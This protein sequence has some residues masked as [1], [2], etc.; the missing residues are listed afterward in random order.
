MSMGVK[1]PYGVLLK[2]NSQVSQPQKTERKLSYKVDSGSIESRKT[3]NRI[4]NNL[5][6]KNTEV[7][8]PNI[9]LGAVVD[10]SRTNVT[11][12]IWAP[13]VDPRKS[14]LMV[15]VRSK[16]DSPPMEDHS[17]EEREKIAKDF[18]KGVN[19][20]YF[21]KNSEAKFNPFPYDY[22]KIMNTPWHYLFGKV[23]PDN[24]RVMKPVGNGVF[25]CK[26]NLNKDLNLKD[27]IDSGLV[28][29]FLIDTDKTGKEFTA[30]K[31]PRTKFQP[32]DTEGWSQIIREDSYKWKNDKKWQNHPNRLTDKKVKSST[33]MVATEIHIGTLTKEGNFDAAMKKLDDI[34][35]EGI[36]NTVEVMPVNEFYGHMNWGYDGN[37]WF[38]PESSYCR[39]DP[40]K[41]D[42]KAHPDKFKEFVD[43]AHGL[44]LNV[45]LDAVY[46]HYGPFYNFYDK[47]GPY[48]GGSN[49]WGK[50]PNLAE[51]N[52]KRYGLDSVKHWLKDFHVDGLRLDA[53]FAYPVDTFMKQMAAE[54]RSDKPKNPDE[55]DISQSV[56]IAEEYR[57]SGHVTNPLNPQDLK[58]DFDK[59]AQAE[60]FAR[61]NDE[62]A[63]FPK[64]LDNLGMNKLW[65][66]E[67][68]HAIE[69]ISTEKPDSL[70][71][72]TT[73]FNR[74]YVEP[75]YAKTSK[76][77]IDRME[78]VRH[79]EGLSKPGAQNLVNYTESH[80]EP[81]NINGTRLIAKVLQ[82]KLDNLNFVNIEPSHPRPQQ[83]KAAVLLKLLNT[84]AEINKSEN[85]FEKLGNQEWLKVQKESGVDNPVTKEQFQQ[86]YT[87]AKAANRL[88]LGTVFMSPGHKMIFMGGEDGEV[89]PFKFFADYPVTGLQEKIAKPDDKGYPIGK[90]AFAE[91]KT[92]R[93]Y[94]KDSK[95]K[96][97][98]QKLAEI[99]KENPALQTA[100]YCKVKD[101]QVFDKQNVMAVHRYKNDNE[102][103]AVMNY[104]ENN[105]SGDFW[106]KMPQ[107]KW[108]EVLNSDD[109]EFG[110]NGVL[111]NEKPKKVKETSGSQVAINLP[112]K[113]ILVFK[114]V[115]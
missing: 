104:G 80:D 6:F 7:K 39:K 108:Q 9:K 64:A 57:K 59:L 78:A 4:L 42:S 15:Q 11:F 94:T 32:F 101:M 47:L 38:A 41:P 77:I 23:N 73:L 107:G 28:Y 111:A 46:N 114:K 93:S 33:P 95:M 58:L 45:V 90:E 14:N 8:A 2:K 29:R 103:F 52:V 18:V 68:M 27:N 110:G 82:E 61:E 105:Y 24:T 76:N 56:L 86:A 37:D 65:N 54:I 63:R 49:G 62:P 92:D 85:G 12:R 100:E 22:K 87:E 71:K 1:A 21:K 16:N 17:P 30:V 81:G 43:K 20:D 31:D 44:G 40:N 35:K 75:H 112:K 74:G 96:K 70:R 25:E 69:D 19:K 79:R 34:A 60:A 91:S 72:L 10:S 55:Y 3:N 50:V 84:Y 51:P 109:S 53:T 97:Y 99:F 83:K 36:F 115:S 106:V 48:L 13:Y 89:A 67:F 5:S 66:Y 88:A 113:S 98:T 26:V 102:I